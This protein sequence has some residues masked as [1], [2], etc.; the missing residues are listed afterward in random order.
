MRFI[1]L[2]LFPSNLRDIAAIIFWFGKPG[3]QQNMN[4]QAVSVLY[5]K[6]N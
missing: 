3:F 6:I 4:W 2:I 5:Y 1:C